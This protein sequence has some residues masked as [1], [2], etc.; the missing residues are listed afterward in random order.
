M[1]LGTIYLVVASVLWG[2]VHSVLASHAAK[3]VLRRFSGP[4][5][6][7][8]LYRFSYNFFS[9]SSLFPIAAMLVTFPDRLLY[10]IPAPWVYVTS[11]IQGLALLMLMATIM[12]TGLFEFLGLAQLSEMGEGKAPV[13]VTNGWYAYIRHPLYFALLLLFWLVPEMTLNRL[14]VIAMFSLYLFVGTYFEERKLLKDFG[15]AYATYQAKTP[16]FIPKTINRQYPNSGT[17]S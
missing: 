11:V 16:M 14:A 3:D 10:S 9:L 2:A 6:F 17:M 1:M 7:N 8:R 12:Q 5:A 15:G 4:V 13:L